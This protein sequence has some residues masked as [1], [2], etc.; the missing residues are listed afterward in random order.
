MKVDRIARNELIDLVNRYLEGD[1]STFEF[2]EK[3]FELSDQTQ[4]KTIS[5]IVELLSCFYDD[6][7]DRKVDLDKNQWNYI[8]RLL[9]ILHSEAHL[10]V[11]ETT[12]KSPTQF[13]ASASLGI[14]LLGCWWL[15][16][17]PMMPLLT[18]GFGF[19][20]IA[21]NMWKNWTPEQ[22]PPHRL[23]LAP[24]S[25]YGEI[26]EVRES[27]ST[28]EKRK[29][30]EH[31]ATSQLF[32]DASTRL[33]LFGMYLQWLVASPL[34]LLEMCFPDRYYHPKVILNGDSCRIQGH[35]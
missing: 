20:A 15:E 22:L 10:V 13:V 3:I 9:L 24:F 2:D 26:W 4:D 31:M 30:P 17:G 25:S 32:R 16:F 33:S 8:Q 28:F 34:V 6:C 5:E 21:I 1:L 23:V 18:V 19:V 12:R 7:Y 11:I 14:L 35:D 27:V 29:W